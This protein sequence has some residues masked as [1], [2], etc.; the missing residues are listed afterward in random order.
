MHPRTPF[1]T[2]CAAVTLFAA[3]VPAAAQ[4]VR[5]VG[6][7]AFDSALYA[8]EA[9]RYTDALQRLDRL[10]AEGNARYRTPIALLTGE[11]YH[12]TTLTTDGRSARW[13]RIAL[14]IGALALVAIAVMIWR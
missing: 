4:V 13:S 8:W 11:L 1:L 12:T 3:T 7:V 2:G 10:L 9:G 14:W 6:D 5:P